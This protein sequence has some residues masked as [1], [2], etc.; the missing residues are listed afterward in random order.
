[1]VGGW[2]WLTIVVKRIILYLFSAGNLKG[3]V[4]AQE[5]EGWWRRPTT[6]IGGARIN[7]CPCLYLFF[8]VRL[9]MKRGF[10]N[11]ISPICL[12][13]REGRSE[14]KSTSKYGSK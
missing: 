4:P 12:Q 5:R 1:M 7:N 6:R 9:Q 11:T 2:G 13:K 8:G 14:V 3:R 10:K